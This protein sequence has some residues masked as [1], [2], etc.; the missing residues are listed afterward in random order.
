[1]NKQRLGGKP[2]STTHAP[3]PPITQPV[4]GRDTS[5]DGVLGSM[6]SG[7]STIDAA[8]WHRGVIR[9]MDRWIAN[10]PGVPLS[11]LRKTR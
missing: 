7:V 4:L 2:R 6:R 8:S 11:Q 3:V 9:D 10:N 5:G 1:M